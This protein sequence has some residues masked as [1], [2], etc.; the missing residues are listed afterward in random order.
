MCIIWQCIQYLF[1]HHGQQWFALM[2][3]STV[4]LAPGFVLVLFSHRYKVD[5][6][7]DCAEDP[8]KGLISSN[9][10][11]QAG[12]MYIWCCSL[13]ISTTRLPRVRIIFSFVSR[14]SSSA[15]EAPVHQCSYHK[16]LLDNHAILSKY[17]SSSD[18]LGELFC[19]SITE[20]S[21]IYWC[22]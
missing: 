13:I 11:E 6:F 1:H 21:G 17:I 19:C 2:Y 7:L 8:G 10:S 3:C 12:L 14:Y 4:H 22:S 16:T 5:S 18:G 20:N 9:E 15:P